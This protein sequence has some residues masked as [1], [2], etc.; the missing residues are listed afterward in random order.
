MGVILAEFNFH[1]LMAF[2]AL[3]VT[4]QD[5]FLHG[6]WFVGVSLRLSSR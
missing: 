4:R 1:E 5:T 6:G 2:D 3:G